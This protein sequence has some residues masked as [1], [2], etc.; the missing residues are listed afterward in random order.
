[1]SRR[2]ILCI[3]N[4]GIKEE[5]STCP[6]ALHNWPLPDGYIAASEV[7]G[8][9][10]SEGWSNRKCKACGLHGWAPGRTAPKPERDQEVTA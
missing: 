10:L 5:R 7:A 1:M 2:T 9:R 8:A 3:P 6:D 4:Y